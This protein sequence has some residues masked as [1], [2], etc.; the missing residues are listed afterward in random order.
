MEYLNINIAQR[1]D[2]NDQISFD[3]MSF[4]VNGYIKIDTHAFS[5]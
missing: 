3:I 4:T 5:C 1:T 2:A